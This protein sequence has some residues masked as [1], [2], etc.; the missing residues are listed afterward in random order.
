MDSEFINKYQAPYI[1]KALLFLKGSPF[2]RIS[3]LCES[4]LFFEGS[5]FA[6]AHARRL[7]C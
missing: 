5:Q 2:H 1:Q 7:R 4:G 6:P 3:F